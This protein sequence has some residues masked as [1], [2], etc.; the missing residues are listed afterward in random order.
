MANSYSNIKISS[1]TSPAI[2]LILFLSRHSKA[3]LFWCIVQGYGSGSVFNRA[4]RSESVFGIRIQEGK[5]DPQKEKKFM[6][7]SVGWPLLWAAGFFCNLDTLYGGLGI[8]K[9]RFL[10]IKKIEFFSTVIFFKFLVIKALD[11][12]PYWSPASTSGFGSGSVKNEY[13]PET[14]VSSSSTIYITLESTVPVNATEREKS[15]LQCLN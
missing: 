15:Y 1:F 2:S 9:L 14:L 5:N 4:S 6:F 7:C 10:I 13:G 3:I 11:P 12:D 8:G